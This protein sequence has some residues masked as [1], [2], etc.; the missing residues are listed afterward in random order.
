MLDE[1]DCAAGSLREAWDEEAVDELDHA[2]Q[3]AARAIDD[4]A[5]DE[6]V[7]AAALHDLAHSPM[8]DASAA[9]Q[10]DATAEAW[11]TP[12]FGE[13]VGWLAG[14]H[15]AAKRYLVATDPGYASTLTA[16]SVLRLTRRAAQG[17]TRPC[18]HIRG[19]PTR[20]ACVATTTPPRIPGSPGCDNRRRV[21]DRGTGYAATTIGCESS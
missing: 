2:L 13:R 4:G 16:T 1:T 3:S 18:S 19:G 14:T 12:G 17:W 20:C 21:G 6:L 15:V 9:A 8:F 7:L 5:D 10:H 11:L